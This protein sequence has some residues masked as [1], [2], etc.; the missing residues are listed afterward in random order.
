VL[1][2]LDTLA[3]DGPLEMESIMPV[4]MPRDQRQG[5]SLTRITAAVMIFIVTLVV[6]VF[7]GLNIHDVKKSTEKDAGSALERE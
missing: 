5:R 7:V 6:I 2:P 3:V 4:E 1:S